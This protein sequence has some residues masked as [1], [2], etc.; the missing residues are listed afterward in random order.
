ENGNSVIAVGETGEG[1]A[2][3]PPGDVDEYTFAGTANQEVAVFLQTFTGSFGPCLTLDLLDQAGT[4]NETRLGNR[5]TSCATP[6][7]LTGDG[8][9]TGRVIL[10]RTASY[11]VRVQGIDSDHA[12]GGYRLR[13]YPVNRA[14]ES[15]KGR[16]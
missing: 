11:T 8:R 7:T 14:A 12:Q 16:M 9:S 5:V 10:P 15:V 3:D 1:E 6:S 13:L 4:L 2:L